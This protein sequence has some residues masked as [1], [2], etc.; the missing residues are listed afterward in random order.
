[1]Y[2]T[3][4]GRTTEGEPRDAGA[5]MLAKKFPSA[6]VC[7]VTFAAPRAGNAEF[8]QAFATLVS[9]SLR[10]VYNYDAVPTVP[11]WYLGWVPPIR[12]V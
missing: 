5:C 3:Q 6:D 4:V 11:M 2:S 12:L 8:D 1:M 9:T 10:F 7:A